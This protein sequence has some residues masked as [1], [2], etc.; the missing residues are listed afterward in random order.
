MKQGT[1]FTRIAILVLFLGVVCYLGI[2]AWQGLTDPFTTTLAYA[3]TQNDSVEADGIIVRQEQVVPGQSGIVSLRFDEGERV[4]VGQALAYLYQSSEAVERQH[5]IRALTLEA[6]QLEYAMNQTDSADIARLDLTIIEETVALR[7]A[8]ARG[9]FSQLED[10]VLELKSTVLRRSYTYGETG[11]TTLQDQYRQIQQE[12]SSLRSQAEQDTSSVTAPVSGTFSALVDGYETLITPATLGDLTPSS[13]EALLD[14]QVEEDTTALCKLITDPRWY[15]AAIL[16]T[17]DAQRL[18]ED[19]VITL[20]FS[21]DF[22]GDLAARVESVSPEEDGRMV[23]IFSSSEGL[24]QTTLLR[25]QTVEIIFDS[26][27]G[28]RVPKQ[29][30]HLSQETVTDPDTGEETTRTVYGVYAVVGARA[31]FKPV[32]ILEES[33]EFY[34]VASVASD[35]TALRA[36][37]EIIVSAQ[38][39]YDGKVVR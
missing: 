3:Y 9:D 17:E 10:Q 7:A 37:D 15:F 24:A 23:V 36:G 18:Q 33:G 11:D 25:R 1:L 32:E 8:A 35:K 14:R 39:L 20:R 34:I 6:Q 12:L 31:E 38:D 5:T 30:V 29:S 22:S 16:D 4:G 2:Y 21:R 28:L 27:S 13:M 19:D 26:R